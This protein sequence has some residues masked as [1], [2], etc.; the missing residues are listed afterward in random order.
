MNQSKE[1]ILQTENSSFKIKLH[2]S[3]DLTIEVIEL[4][5]IKG[6]YYLNNYSLEDLAKLSKGFKVCED[7]N[8]AFNMIG[9][10]LEDKNAFIKESNENGILLVI[11]LFMPNGTTQEVNLPLNKKEKNNNLLNIE[12]AEKV[13]Q[14]EEENKNLK[15]KLNKLESMLEYLKEEIQNKKI[16]EE[17]GLNTKIIENKEELGF[18]ANRIINFDENLRKKKIKYNLLYRATRDGDNSIS[19][20]SRVDGRTPLL[21]IIETTE[22]IKFGFYNE[23]QFS[24]YL[25]IDYDS[26]RLEIPYPQDN[27][28]FIFSLTLKKIYNIKN[29]AQSFL[30]KSCLHYSANLVTFKNN[31]INISYNCLS[32]NN[33]ETCT[34][35]NADQNFIGF[36]KDY[37]LNNGA[38]NFQIKEMETFLIKFE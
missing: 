15:E 29:G 33:C 34:K 37:E 30:N 6:V 31:L 35:S 36:E 23:Q 21:T 14:L 4:S 38:K 11:K 12:L 5:K 22:G 16:I 1:Y 24:N 20:H 3:T 25:Y 18:I 7:I 2:L 9:K 13:N 19:F 32:L 28:F 17:L 10:I 26:I 8:E 27:K